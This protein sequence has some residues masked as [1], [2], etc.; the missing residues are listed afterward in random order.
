MDSRVRCSFWWVQVVQVV[1]WRLLPSNAGHDG[2]QHEIGATSRDHEEMGGGVGTFHPAMIAFTLIFFSLPETKVYLHS[3]SVST[4]TLTSHRQRT[5]E[6]LD[7]IFGVP[8]R[9]HASYYAGTWFPW[10]FKRYVLFQGRAKLELLY[11]L[12][13]FGDGIAVPVGALY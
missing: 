10:V 5:L 11:Q 3:P 1:G 6:E 4:A 13:G 2:T 7:F 12:D 8:T 9:R